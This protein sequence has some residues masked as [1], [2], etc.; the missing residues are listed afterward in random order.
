MPLSTQDF[1]RMPS[2]IARFRDV[3]KERGMELPGMAPGYYQALG[4]RQAEERER[5]RH[6]VTTPEAWDAERERFLQVYKDT[7]GPFPPAQVEVIPRETI[8]K[9]DVVIHK[10]LYSTFTDNWVPANIFLPRTVAAPV[11]AVATPCG[12]SNAGKIGYHHRALQLAQNGYAAITWDWIGMGER[13]LTPQ[14]PYAAST[15]H[16]L[17]GDRMPLAG[18][19]FAWF[20]VQ[21]AMAAVTVLQGLPEVDSARIGITGSSGG[22]WLSVYA[23][24]MDERIKVSVPAASVSSLR[25]VINAH[26]SEQAYFDMQRKGVHYPDLIGFLICPRPLFIVS[27]SHDIWKIETTEYAHH[28]AARLYEVMGVPER[29]GMRTWD[30][31][32]NY[33]E[34]QFT[35]GMQWLNRWLKNEPDAPVDTRTDPENMVEADELI[36]CRDESVFAEGHPMPNKVFWEIA[37]REI[38]PRK[39]LGGFL[40]HLKSSVTQPVNVS[41]QELDRFIP[42]AGSGKRI[43]FQPEEGMLLPAEVLIPDQPRGI[44]LL[45]DRCDRREDLDWQMR[46]FRDGYAVF[47]PDLRGWGETSP[48]EDWADWEGW[49]RSFYDSR[50]RDLYALALMTGRNLVFDR[51]RD[52]L[53][54]LDVAL[55]LLPG[56]E[57][58]AWGRRQGALVTLYAALAD[59]RITKL[60]VENCLASYRDLMT[61]DLPVYRAEGNVFGLLRWGVDLSDLLEAYAGDL[62]KLEPEPVVL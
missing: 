31:G 20:M 37:Q 19:S 52:L 4:V 54:L 53:A 9:R 28:E 2:P 55:Q 34:D 11:P 62:V 59:T 48:P 15:Y 61:E 27:N 41:W 21:E 60:I 17:V 45:A 30:R 22:G 6:A 44:L 51:A 29:I 50:Q 12:H 1:M 3:A 58:T 35:V 18:Y 23:A 49:S 32:H 47:R 39:D 25:H 43:C 40:A 5:I 42:G 13:Q 24:A 10:I 56:L 14:A 36:V 7:L 33:D 46:C 38:G 57:V 26:D 16:N 8:E